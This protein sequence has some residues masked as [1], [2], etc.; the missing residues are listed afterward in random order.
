MSAQI[1]KSRITIR[2]KLEDQSHKDYTYL[3]VFE[4]KIKPIGKQLE[5]EDK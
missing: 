5:R 2:S 3:E 4:Q 1:I